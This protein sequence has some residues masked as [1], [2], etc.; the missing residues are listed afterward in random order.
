V[1]ILLAHNYYQ[2]RGGEDVVVEQELEL[3]RAKGHA[4]ALHS[5]HND[6][7]RG[8]RRTASAGALAVYNPAARAVLAE[9]LRRFR[10]DIVHVHNFFPQL[11]PSLFD[12]CRA[13]DVPS[14]MTLHNFRLLCPTSILFL[15]GKIE[16]RSLTQSAMWAVGRRAYQGSA[17]ATLPL[18]LMVDFHK[19]AGTWRRKVDVFV[20]L[21]E[22]AKAKFVAGGLPGD[23]IV[24]KA[25]AA[26][27]P[28]P[29]VEARARLGALYVGRLSPEKGLATLIEAWRGLDVPLRIAGDGPLRDLCERAQEPNVTYLGPL[30]R[31]RVTEEMRRAAFLVLPSTCY[32]MFPMT[33]VE[34]YANG[35]PV[36]GSRLGGLESLIDDGVT[37]LAFAPGD[38]ADL[39]AKAAW[40][41]AHPAETARMGAQARAAYEARYTAQHNYENLMAIYERARAR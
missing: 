17:M 23:R 38:A 19:W 13:A 41:A 1:R 40:A 21:T 20:A 31:S 12:A 15:N 34:A 25:N 7:I 39:R 27:D 18:A 22:F 8:W 24:V 29:P 10:P 3:L 4:V 6:D 30:E 32:E 35:L 33:L 9:E 37:G 2:Q 28:G 36:L 14:V 16:E 26:A 11:S 5:V